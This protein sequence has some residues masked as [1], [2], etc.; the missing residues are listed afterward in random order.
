MAAAPGSADASTEGS[1]DR[2][3]SNRVKRLRS[4]EASLASSSAGAPVEI[5]RDAE[6]GEL[7]AAVQQPA[8]PANGGASSASSDPGASETSPAMNPKNPGDLIALMRHLRGLSAEA[9]RDALLALPASTRQ[10][11]EL[12]LRSPKLQPSS[13]S[14]SL[15]SPNL[16]PGAAGS[17]GAAAATA[18]GAS[19]FAILP[20]LEL[21]PAESAD[22]GKEDAAPGKP[23][24]ALAKSRGRGGRGGGRGARKAANNSLVSTTDTSERQAPANPYRA[25]APSINPFHEMNVFQGRSRENVASLAKH[26]Q[27]LSQVD[28]LAILAMLPQRTCWDLRA[29]MVME[30][31]R[32][33]A[34][35]GAS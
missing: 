16:A 18:A 2:P 15:L 10:K 22:G 32:S 1:S 31:R 24:Q 6:Q 26:L 28:R 11:L 33:Q 35:S 7:R 30:K 17:S 29:H 34:A 23:V 8:R 12:C 20:S 5:R 3:D 9:R 14:A 27:S 19:D 21:P 4:S 25:S 13:P